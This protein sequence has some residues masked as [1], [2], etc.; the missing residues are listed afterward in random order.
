MASN[1]QGYQISASEGDIVVFDM[2]TY[3]YGDKILFD[4]LVRRKDALEQW[5]KNVC[6]EFKCSYKFFVTAN[7]W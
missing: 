5:A 1:S 7:Y 4:E 6:K 2:V 3:G